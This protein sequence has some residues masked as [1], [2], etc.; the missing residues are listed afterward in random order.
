M[1]AAKRRRTTIAIGL[2]AAA[3]VAVLTL[4]ALH[5]PILQTPP[6]VSGPPGSGASGASFGACSTTSAS[7]PA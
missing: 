7:N 2:S 1:G 3:H 6:M 5:A 4:V